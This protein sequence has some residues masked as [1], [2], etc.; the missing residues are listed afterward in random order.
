MSMPLDYNAIA[1]QVLRD[2]AS[3]LLESVKQFQKPNDLEA[4]VRLI[5]KAKKRG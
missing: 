2:E 5:L 1:A 4:V 3:A